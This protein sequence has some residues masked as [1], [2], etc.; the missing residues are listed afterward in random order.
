MFFIVKLDVLIF[1][2]QR[3]ES[4]NILLN[5]YFLLFSSYWSSSPS[6]PW[7]S[8]REEIF[9]KKPDLYLHTKFSSLLDDNASNVPKVSKV[10]GTFFLP[11]SS[12]I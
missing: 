12:H 1:I 9:L 5:I 10:N 2:F 3:T 7:Y 6:M 4:E 11:S 8:N